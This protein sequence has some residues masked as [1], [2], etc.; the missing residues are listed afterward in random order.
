MC[1]RDRSHFLTSCRLA[2]SPNL[3]ICFS[4]GRYRLVRSLTSLAS[5]IVYADTDEYYQHQRHQLCHQVN[6]CRL[7]EIVTVIHYRFVR[8]HDVRRN[9]EMRRE[10]ALLFSRDLRFPDVHV[11]IFTR[12]FTRAYAVLFFLLWL[13]ILKQIAKRSLRGISVRFVGKLPTARIHLPSQ[14]GKLTGVP[15]TLKLYHIVRV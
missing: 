12:K 3:F 8:L 13:Q 11:L 14:N 15:R 10:H 4:R 2:L 5:Y 9:D 6:L 7:F 1:I